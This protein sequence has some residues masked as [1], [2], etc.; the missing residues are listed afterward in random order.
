MVALTGYL[1][2]A[3]LAVSLMF[4]PAARAE[5]GQAMQASLSASMRA[6]R[7][8]LGGQRSSIATMI[9]PSSGL[10]MAYRSTMWPHFDF[11]LSQMRGSAVRPQLG[12]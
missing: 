1:M 3:V 7:A 9:T 10:I 8:P 5:K 11:N 4:A 6:S 12:N 2:A